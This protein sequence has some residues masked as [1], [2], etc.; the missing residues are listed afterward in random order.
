[1]EMDFLLFLQTL[2]TPALDFFFSKLTLLGNGGIFW[3]LCALVLLCTKKYRK[4]GILFLLSLLACFLPGNVFLK[5]VVARERPCW[6]NT[7]VLLLISNPKDFSFPSGH[8]MH[9]FVGALSLWYA[10]KKWGIAA[11]ILAGLIAFSRMYLFVH[12]PTD[13]LAGIAIGLIIT[14]LIHKFLGRVLFRENGMKA[15]IIREDSYH[16]DV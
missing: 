9:S 12:Y 5:N 6:V 2:H 10:N 8:S 4:C 11:F 16:A 1:M 15:N 3:I 7:N 14:F 13:V